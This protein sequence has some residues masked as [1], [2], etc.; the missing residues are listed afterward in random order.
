MN[1]QSNLG[2]TVWQDKRPVVADNTTTESVTRKSRDGSK[3]PVSCPSSVAL[4][5]KYMGGVDHNDQAR[6]YYHV[7]LNCRKFY[8][9]TIGSFLM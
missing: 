3:A 4:Y 8:K 1:V 7:Q 2:I 6:G 5:N 9:Y